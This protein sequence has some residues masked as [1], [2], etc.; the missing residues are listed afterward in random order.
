MVNLVFLIIITN[1]VYA[2]DNKPVDTIPEGVESV[3]AVI[4]IFSQK[5]SFTLPTSWKAVF[6]DQQ[7][8]SYMIEFIPQSEVIENWINLFTIQGFKD[9]ADKTMPEGFLNALAVRF[10]ETCG[11][12]AVFEKLG[13][14]SIS[15]HP[16][17]AAVI[18]CEI[19]L[20]MMVLSV[21]MG[22]VKSVITSL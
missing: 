15:N 18:G 5:V 4:P 13:P 20:T 6:E 3:P 19:C 22:K 7:S 9:I 11:E 8:G 16:A 21:K 17:F 12:Y 14:M 1:V 2:V 10:Q